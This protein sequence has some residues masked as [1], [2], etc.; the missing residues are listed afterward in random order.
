MNTIISNKCKDYNKILEFIKNNEN[1]CINI[2]ENYI[3][4]LEK[5]FDLDEN[6]QNLIS[7]LNINNIINVNKS[8]KEIYD[9][10]KEL[11]TILKNNDIGKI[12]NNLESVKDIIKYEDINDINPNKK[13]WI[14]EELSLTMVSKFEKND[15]SKIEMKLN[16]VTTEIKVLKNKY[17]NDVTKSIKLIREMFN[18]NNELNNIKSLLKVEKL[19]D[20]IQIYKFDSIN[21]NQKIKNDIKKMFEENYDNLDFKLTKLDENLLKFNN[22]YIEDIIY[23]NKK[24]E[25]K[26]IEVKIQENTKI[27]KKIQNLNQIK[28]LINYLKY[29]ILIDELND[30]NNV[31][32]IVSNLEICLENLY[33]I[34]TI[35]KLYNKINKLEELINYLS[36]SFD[37][38]LRKK[39]DRIY[40][41]SLEIYVCAV[42]LNDEHYIIINNKIKT[43]TTEF[44]EEYTSIMCQH[45]NNI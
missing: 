29:T 23:N 20:L 27:Q 40:Y 35:Y 37:R 15:I 26:D 1:D 44:K 24:Y 36:N 5:I 19:K 21:K 18:D 9:I 22:K 11:I 38:E 13:K 2:L 8:I 43:I 31:N 30:K 12:I 28:D 39:I 41:L 32:N 33:K 45:D 10:I 42:E 6:K 25:K 17:I 3:F 16:G 14:V 7:C 34:S 4:I